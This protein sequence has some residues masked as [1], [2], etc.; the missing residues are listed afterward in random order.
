ML[1]HPTVPPLEVQETLESEEFASSV[2]NTVL[3]VVTAVGG[4]GGEATHHAGVVKWNS[5][6]V[7]DVKSLLKTRAMFDPHEM[8]S[9]KGVEALLMNTSNDAL[10]VAQPVCAEVQLEGPHG[11]GLSQLFLQGFQQEKPP[12][13]FTQSFPPHV[14]PS[15]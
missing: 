7:A 10:Y 9:L 8:N 13:V 3:L 11:T 6:P 4:G 15:P 14:A 2:L 12:S 5:A 1:K